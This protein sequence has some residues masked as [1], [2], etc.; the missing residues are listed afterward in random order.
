MRIRTLLVVMILSICA[1]F[2]L[3]TFGERRQADAEASKSEKDKSKKAQAAAQNL[4]VEG[5]IRKM[6]DYLGS[7]RAFSCRIEADVEVKANGANNH[8][9][10]KMTA[11]LER[12]NRLALVLEEGQMGMTI[13]S[14]GKQ[15]VQYM[16]PLKRY[17]VS[18][19]PATLADLEKLEDSPAIQMLHMLPLPTSGEAFY[20]ALMSGVTKSEYLGTEKVGQTEC[21]H[22]RLQQEKFDWEIWIA[23]GDKPLIQKVVPDLAKQF[24]AAG[25]RMKDVK[26]SYL[27][28]FKDWNVAPKF[29]DADFAFTPPADA[30]KVDSLLEGLQGRDE[31]GPHP[32]LGQPAPAFATVDLDEHPFDLK[33]HLGKDVILLDFW[34]TW[35]G[36][37]VEALPKVD[38]AA[39]KFAGKGLVFRAVNC[40]EE[41]ATIKEFLTSSKLDSP[42]ALDTKNEIGPAYK[43]EGIPQTVLIGK[44]G[45]VQVV[46]VGYSENIGDMLSSEIQDLL[47]GKDLAGPQLKK[48]SD[49][50]KKRSVSK[51]HVESVGVAADPASNTVYAVGA[52]SG[53]AVIDADGKIQKEIS[54]DTGGKLRLANLAGD[55][56]PE[57]IVSETWGQNIKAYLAT[58][59][60]LWEYPGGEGVD[61]VWA[62]DLNGDGKDEVIV[63]YNGGTGLHVLDQH[64]KLL[65]KFEDIGNVWHVTAGD[66]NNDGKPDVVTT[67]AA[68][69]LHVFDKAGEKLKDIR[70]SIYA[71]MVRMA[72]LGKDKNLAIVSGSGSDAEKL[73]AVDFEGKEKWSLELQQGKGGTV[74]DLAIGPNSWAAVAM[75]GGVINVVDL[76][77]GHIIARASD[78]GQMPQVTW[79]PRKDK[80]PL[81]V[82]ATG[83]DINAFEVT[84]TDVVAAEKKADKAGKPA[85]ETADGSKTPAE[86]PAN[87]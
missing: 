66:F 9:T 39:K 83:K 33:K 6:A 32:L 34:A 20:K 81:L 69:M 44:D 30:E 55:A 48:A 41:A 65:W 12:P 84:P 60:L 16:P 70:V 10:T 1:G 51:K 17:T 31:E 62:A 11:R 56:T 75:R 24:A 29:T 85:A 80:S 57:L 42:V 74:D 61:D 59:K 49:A 45:K 8:M 47:D 38:A 22:C 15:L 21:H 14:D 86:P 73:I 71:N 25:G 54:V 43:V 79:L 76:D 72:K 50:R 63:G 2:G 68:G 37:C 40:G 64:G 19:A 27:V 35:C 78:Q 87:P 67:S 5:V 53:A 77:A 7:L 58:G 23:T 82:V 3:Q 46:H 18:P 52:K 13:I 4:K 28:A 26:I 36:P